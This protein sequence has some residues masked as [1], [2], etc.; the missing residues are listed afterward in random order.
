MDSNRRSAIYSVQTGPDGKP[1]TG[2][3]SDEK[4]TGADP[5]KSGKVPNPKKKEGAAKE[6]VKAV[7][8]LPSKRCYGC[9]NPAPPAGRFCFKCV[10][11]K[12][13]TSNK[14]CNNYCPLYRK[15]ANIR[16]HPDLSDLSDHELLMA[17]LNMQRCATCWWSDCVYRLSFLNGK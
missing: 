9:L 7:N 6:A 16:P 8:P 5:V 17:A 2:E 11:R 3:R 12:S 13:S 14:M 4:E 1:L 15:M 10:N